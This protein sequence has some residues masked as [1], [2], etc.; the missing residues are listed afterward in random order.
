MIVAQTSNSSFPLPSRGSVSATKSRYRYWSCRRNDF[1]SYNLVATER[2]LLGAD[3][4]VN[5]DLVEVEPYNIR[6]VE[7]KTFT[8]HTS[9]ERVR[10]GG[11]FLQSEL[12]LLGLG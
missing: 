3:F 9:F 10:G 5:I 7:M 2:T 12:R 8:F 4:G 6:I 11:D 1:Q